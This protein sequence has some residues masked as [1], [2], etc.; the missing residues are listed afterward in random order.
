MLVAANQDSNM[1]EGPQGRLACRRSH[2]LK[3]TCGERQESSEGICS[4]PL[5]PI[6]YLY[7]TLELFEATMATELLKRS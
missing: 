6:I 4:F 3:R 5:L 1:F 2:E 7:I